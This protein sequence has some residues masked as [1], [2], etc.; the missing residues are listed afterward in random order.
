MRA[1]LDVE[2]LPTPVRLWAYLGSA[3]S[4]KGDWYQWLLQP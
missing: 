3:W 4:L 2:S 1:D